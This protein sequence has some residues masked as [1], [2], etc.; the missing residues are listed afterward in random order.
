MFFA[1]KHGYTDLHF[2]MTLVIITVVLT[3]CAL[4]HITKPDKN[5]DTPQEQTSEEQ[6]ATTGW[7]PKGTH[8]ADPTYDHS[9]ENQLSVFN[10][11]NWSNNSDNR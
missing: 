9:A 7:G 10:L 2:M 6:S 11:N 8:W 5:P 4:R 3:A 1:R